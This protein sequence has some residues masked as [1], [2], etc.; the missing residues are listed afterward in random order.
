MQTV[1]LNGLYFP[2]VDLLSSIALAVVLG[3]GG[4][5]YFDG[6]VTLGTLFAFMLYVQ[7]FFDPVQQLSQLYNTFLSATAALDKII[8][9]L[10]EEP[11]V[12][13][14]P[15]A[16]DL[17]ADRRARRASRASASATAAATRC[18]TGSTSTS[19]PGRRSRSSAT[20]APAS[21]RSRSCSPASTTRRDGR[22]TIDGHDLHDVTQASLRRQLGHRA[23]GGLPLRRHGARQHRLRPA[24]RDAGARS[25]QAAQTVGAHDFI[26]RL[27]DG[28]ETQLGE[29]GSR[30]SLGQR[31]L[32]A[33]A[34]ALLAD[35]RIL[36]PRRGDVVGR[37]RHRAE[38]RARAARCC[39][40]AGPR[41]SSRTA[42]RRSATPT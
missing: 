11:E 42:S 9:V 26:L 22:I 12:V 39:S 36:D 10:D 33:F 4:H 32:V 28:Y 3:Y 27:E 19:P 15:D 17:P 23:A 21:R 20:P 29:R 25:S 7:N 1:V 38:D 14:R 24:R 2:F 30:L 37:H 5:L 31:Q 8:D 18:C 6:G 34:R 13:D 40:P 35:P 16:R 41:S